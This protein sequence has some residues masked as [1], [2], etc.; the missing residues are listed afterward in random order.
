MRLFVAATAAVPALAGQ[1]SSQCSAD[2]LQANI[3]NKGTRYDQDLT[4]S[5]SSKGSQEPHVQ[6]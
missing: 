4:G 5:K 3:V 2:M 1:C 6:L